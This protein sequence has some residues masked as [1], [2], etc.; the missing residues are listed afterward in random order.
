MKI[1]TIFLTI[2]EST[3][4][5]VYL[6]KEKKI[7]AIKVI[8]RKLDSLKFLFKIAWEIEVLDNKA[9]ARIS[10]PLFE[11]GKILGGWLK[12]LKENSPTVGEK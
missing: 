4:R 7:S 6:E 12:Y 11:S 1:D 5:S 3:Q 2:L 9:Y 10:E 8:I